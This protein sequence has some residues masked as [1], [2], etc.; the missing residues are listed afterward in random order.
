MYAGK[1]LFFSARMEKNL[2]FS[3]L[4][5]EDLYDADH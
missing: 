4:N 1:F 3:A 5:T 2:K